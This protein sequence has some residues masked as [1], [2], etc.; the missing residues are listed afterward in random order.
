MTKLWKKLNQYYS[1]GSLFNK[2][3]IL[4]WLY[5]NNSIPTVNKTKWKQKNDLKMHLVS[6][7]YNVF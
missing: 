6:E 2:N 5:T 1:H 4:S 3:Y 7:D